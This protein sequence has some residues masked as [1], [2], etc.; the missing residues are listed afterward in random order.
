MTARTDQEKAW[1]AEME[2]L[3]GQKTVSKPIQAKEETH[4]VPAK[5]FYSW[6]ETQ[7]CFFNLWVNPPTSPCP[8][9]SAHASEDIARSHIMKLNVLCYTVRSYW[10]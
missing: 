10:A 4:Q 1:L 6:A 8:T 7:P 5:N 9:L 3:Q 2:V